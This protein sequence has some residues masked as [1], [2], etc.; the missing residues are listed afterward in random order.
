MTAMGPD[1]VCRGDLIA[2]EAWTVWE[3]RFTGTPKYF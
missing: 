1:A 2:T 3:I